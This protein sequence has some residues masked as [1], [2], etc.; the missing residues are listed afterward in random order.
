MSDVTDSSNGD[1][2]AA[3]YYKQAGDAFGRGEL[4]RAEELCRKAASLYE[5]AGDEEVSRVYLLLGAIAYYRSHLDTA[6]RWYHKALE[7]DERNGNELTAP[8]IYDNLAQVV[9]DRG[10]YES[11]EM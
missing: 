8:T 7:I 5:Q 3:S 10:N 1:N 4:E 11:A 9:S 2:P 6:E